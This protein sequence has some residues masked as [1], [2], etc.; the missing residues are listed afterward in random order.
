VL[1]SIRSRLSR[2]MAELK[3]VAELSGGMPLEEF[4]DYDEYWEWRG[5]V[6]VLHERWKIARDLIPDGS[7]VLDV[8]C[9][10]G[11]FLAFLREERPNC[12]LHGID[13]SE[14][15]VEMA[16]AEGILASVLDVETTDI[17]SVADYVTCLEVIE[18]VVQAERV[19]DRLMAACQRQ[20]LISIPNVGFIGCRIRLALFGRFPTTCCVFHTREHVRFWTNKDFEEW[21]EHCGYRLT[22]RCPQHGIWVLWRLLPSLFASGMVYVVEPNS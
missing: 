19:L 1:Q 11:R 12:K 17:N 22:A 13:V 5:Q 21:I 14:R 10:T 18:H 7:S 6:T 2:R 8:G 20:A 16:R 3:R 9:G 4:A 15:A